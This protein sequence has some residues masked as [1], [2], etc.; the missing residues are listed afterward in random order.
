MRGNRERN[1]TWNISLLSRLSWMV[2]HFFDN[3]QGMNESRIYNDNGDP[4]SVLWDTANIVKTGRVLIK[5]K[6]GHSEVSI[7][8]VIN[9]TTSKKQG[10]A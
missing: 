7:E 9:E 8:Y 3:R 4:L 2:H 6:E 5:D 10:K 1:L